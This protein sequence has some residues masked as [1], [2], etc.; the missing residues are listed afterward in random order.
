MK[1]K[2]NFASFLPLTKGGIPSMS[3]GITV[4]VKLFLQ[5]SNKSHLYLR[6]SDINNIMVTLGGKEDFQADA[7]MTFND[8]RWIFA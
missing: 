1:M 7:I 5:K 6:L 8:M 3:V 4:H 2:L